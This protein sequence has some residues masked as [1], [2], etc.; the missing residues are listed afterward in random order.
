LRHTA[1]HIVK[2][3][4]LIKSSGDTATYATWRRGVLILYGSIVLIAIAAVVAM[5]FAGV[6]M[7]LAGK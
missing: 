4:H 2:S 7:D 3:R 6:S 5:Q 1:P